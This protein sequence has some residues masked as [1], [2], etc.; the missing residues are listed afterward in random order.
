MKDIPNAAE[1]IR[2]GKHLFLSFSSFFDRRTKNIDEIT[3]WMLENKI[4]LS[5]GDFSNLFI[6]GSY[7][8]MKKYLTY[9]ADQHQENTMG[10][11]KLK[12]L[13]KLKL[14]SEFKI[15]FTIEYAY[16]TK[17]DCEIVD[18]LAEINY[19]VKKLHGRCLRCCEKHLISIPLK[20]AFL[21][22]D[23]DFVKKF[24][25]TDSEKVSTSFFRDDIQDEKIIEILD[26][27]I[28]N[29]KYEMVPRNYDDNMDRPAILEFFLR[30]NCPLTPKIRGQ[31]AERHPDL[32]SLLVGK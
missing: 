25:T 11:S 30:K 17:H 13:D 14:L 10:L 24:Y 2:K 3:V 28:E 29:E 20:Q 22:Y 31:I 16:M 7:D 15:P 26:F 32:I 27:L 23:L 6:T 18:F 5:D 1:I 19:D 8:N 9:A 21:T 4:I 12:C